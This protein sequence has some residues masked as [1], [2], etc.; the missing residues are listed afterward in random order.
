[1]QLL[2]AQHLDP[3]LDHLVGHRFTTQEFITEFEQ[4]NPSLF[5]QITAEYGRG[6]RGSGKHY[7]ASVHIGKSL[8]AYNGEHRLI[9]LDYIQAPPEWGNNMIAFWECLAADNADTVRV[10][11]SMEDDIGD[12]LSNTELSD[13]ER[14]QLVL[15]RIGQ[16]NFRRNLINYWQRCPVT[17]CEEVRLLTASHIKPWSASLPAERLDPFNGLL[18][19]PNIDRVFDRGLITFQDDGTLLCSSLLTDNTIE[20]LGIQPGI[21]I[22]LAAQHLPYMAYH[23]EHVFESA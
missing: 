22:T 4:Q 10:T 12:L 9:S 19:T 23:R 3:V 6:G 1:M 14:A 17:G 11:N 21:R 13:T 18:L 15:A 5:A 7:S 2:E 16:G 8:G 20:A